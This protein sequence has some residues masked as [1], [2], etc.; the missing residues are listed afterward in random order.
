M[1]VIIYSRHN[2]FREYIKNLLLSNSNGNTDI[3]ILINTDCINAAS[4][5]QDAVIVL[6]VHSDEPYSAC[7]TINWLDKLWQQGLKN[8]VVMLGWLTSD[9]LNKS[10]SADISCYL[11]ASFYKDSYKYLRLPNTAESFLSHIHNV[12]PLN[13]KYHE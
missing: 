3:V 5:N 7:S 4:K 9:Y 13:R 6:D 11:R 10:L 8:P 12:K 1:N 2:C